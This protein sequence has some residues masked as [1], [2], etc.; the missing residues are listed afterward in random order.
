MAK[1]KKMNNHLQNTTQK[2][3][4][5]VTLTAKEPGVNSGA[6]EGLAVPAPL[7]TPVVLF[8]L[9]T[10]WQ[11]MNEERTRKCLGQVE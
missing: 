4:D 11:V 2:T 1:R 3:K 8:Q 7:A 5:R 10:R 9:Q 6:P